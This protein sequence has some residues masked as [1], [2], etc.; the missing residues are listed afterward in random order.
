VR[1]T[2]EG[3]ER[4]WEIQTKRLVEVRGYLDRISQRWDDAIE[5]LRAAVERPMSTE[6]GNGSRA[7]GTP[8]SPRQPPSRS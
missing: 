8:S 6:P 5:R 1:S 4:V 3:R 7:N 2:C